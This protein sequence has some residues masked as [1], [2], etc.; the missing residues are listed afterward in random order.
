MNTA[1][2]FLIAVLSGIMMTIPL[3]TKL[4]NAIQDL[5]KER[6][7]NKIVDE[8]LMYMQ[9]AK[10]MFDADQ[11]AEKKQWVMGMVKM[12]ADKLNYDIDMDAIGELIDAV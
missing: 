6:N 5:A 4:I 8:M 7:W 12:S 9:A 11:G 3:V 10:D 1:L 2:T